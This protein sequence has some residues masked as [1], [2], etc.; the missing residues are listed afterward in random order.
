MRAIAFSADGKVVASGGRDNKVVLRDV[1]TGAPLR[2]MRSDGG[3][4]TPDAAQLAQLQAAAMPTAES[5]AVSLSGRTASVTIDSVP[6]N[7]AYVITL[8]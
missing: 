7:S 8:R 4:A 1:S 3:V 2:L 6:P 5:V